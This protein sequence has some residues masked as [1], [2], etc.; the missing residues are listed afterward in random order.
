MFYFALAC[1]DYV[2][3]HDLDYWK[4]PDM[5]YQYWM[6]LAIVVGVFSFSLASFGYLNGLPS[7]QATA[8]FITSIMLFVA[9]LLDYFYAT[10]ATL[11]G[12]NYHWSGWNFCY[13]IFVANGL[14]SS[15]EW[16]Q[17]IVWSLG[18]VGLIILAWYWALKK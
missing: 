12:E 15:W 6:A 8:T 16:P 4:S 10:I 14:L 7:K 1:M 11:R 9:G 13:K 2:I 3:T 18:C 17:Q 5:L